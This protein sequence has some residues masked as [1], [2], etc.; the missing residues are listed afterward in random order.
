MTFRLDCAI[1]ASK[2]TTKD[3]RYKMNLSRLDLTK[4]LFKIRVATIYEPTT[5]RNSISKRQTNGFLYILNGTYTYKI[6]DKS[7]K[8]VLTVSQNDLIYLPAGCKTYSYTVASGNNAPSK[9]LQIEVEITDNESGEYLSFAD[10]PML[11]TSHIF[12]IKESM[13][14]IVGALTSS[15]KSNE[16]IAYSE[17]I[18]ILSLLGDD[19]PFEKK[20]AYISILP[21]IKHIENN[22]TVKITSAELASLSSMSESQLRRCFKATLGISPKTYQ[23]ELLL[24]SAKNLLSLGEFRISE[25]SD[26]LGFYD[27]YAFSHFF[28]KKAGCSPKKYLNK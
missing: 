2:K 13:F 15:Y 24:K 3:E 28:S 22:Y 6:Q 26:M 18:R 23:G 1:I 21:A 19:K 11:I 14:K 17:L 12:E 5:L 9:S 10:T 7:E 25:I 27:I 20:E 4:S 8:K 16:F